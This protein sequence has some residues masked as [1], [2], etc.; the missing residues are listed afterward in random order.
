MQDGSNET[1]LAAGDDKGPD[2]VPDNMLEFNV[3][4]QMIIHS[5][6]M[7]MQ[8]IRFV[9]LGRQ[10]PVD[11]REHLNSLNLGALLGEGNPGDDEGN[12]GDDN[13]IHVDHGNQ[14]NKNADQAEIDGNL[15]N[16]DSVVTVTDEGVPDFN[17]EDITEEDLESLDPDGVRKVGV[18][19]DNDSD[20][21][22]TTVTSTIAYT[23]ES[24]VQMKFVDNKME[25][26][27]KL[28]P[29]SMFRKL[30]PSKDRY[31]ILNKDEL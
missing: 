17:A 28:P 18:R 2:S 21:S 20:D 16:K 25:E 27:K 6:G 26:D 19:T 11:L 24:L 9:Q 13:V 14:G 22:D 5:N 3:Q 1:A 23:K 4:Q 7:R 10:Q 30:A 8:V 31:T 15:D 12:Q 29:N